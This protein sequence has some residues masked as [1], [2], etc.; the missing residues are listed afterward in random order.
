MAQLKSGHVSIT[1]DRW[2]K[3][4]KAHDNLGQ[5]ISIVSKLTSKILE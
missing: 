4:V 2:K 5:A 1:D 3:M